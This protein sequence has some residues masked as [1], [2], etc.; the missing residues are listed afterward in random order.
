M[1]TCVPPF[2]TACVLSAGIDDGISAG[3]AKTTEAK[4][5]TKKNVVKDVIRFILYPPVPISLHMYEE[6]SKASTITAVILL[7][8]NKLLLFRGQ[9]D[10]CFEAWQV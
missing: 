4:T 6:H 5:S 2:A 7:Y 1:V 10:C 9:H 3:I 8:N